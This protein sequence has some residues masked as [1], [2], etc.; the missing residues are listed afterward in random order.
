[1]LK[2]ILATLIY[3]AILF[4]FK[5]LIPMLR[6]QNRYS[7]IVNLYNMSQEVIK[8]AAEYG[9]H[10]KIGEVELEYKRF[11][12]ICNGMVEVYNELERK[13]NEAIEYYD[14]LGEFILSKNVY[15]QER[16]VLNCIQKS[17]ASGKRAFSET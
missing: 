16:C 9:E 17:I 10:V 5:I 14:K 3:L 13:C 15:V 8:T 7:M 11:H 6:F 2:Y 1:M 12:V 4:V